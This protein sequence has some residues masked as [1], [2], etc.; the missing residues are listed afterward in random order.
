MTSREL[1]PPNPQKMPCCKSLCSG[2]ATE[3]KTADWGHVPEALREAVIERHGKTRVM[4]R[5]LL[6]RLGLR[7]G[8]RYSWYECTVCNEV[9]Y[10]E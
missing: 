10:Y 2:R 6:V 3:R 1:E 4:T 8:T 7:K 5:R 9:C